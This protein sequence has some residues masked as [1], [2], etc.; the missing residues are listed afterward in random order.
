ME[1]LH[2]ELFCNFCKVV[3]SRLHTMVE[4]HTY[5]DYGFASIAYMTDKFGGVYLMLHYDLESGKVIADYGSADE[6]E[7][8]SANQLCELVRARRDDMLEKR[9]MDGV[10]EFINSQY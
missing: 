3:A 1:N 9:D 7:I 6:Q 8:T 2:Y 10:Y 5:N 4:G